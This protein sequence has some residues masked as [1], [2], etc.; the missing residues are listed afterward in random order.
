MTHHNGLTFDGTTKMSIWDDMAK[1]VGAYTGQPRTP[2][3]WYWGHLHLGTVYNAN[4]AAGTACKCRCVGH[5]AFP[6]GD[7][8]GIELQQKNVD[9]NAKTPIAPNNVK[10]QNGFAILTLRPDGSITETFYEVKND[11]SVI[12]AWPLPV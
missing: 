2:D 7:A 5:S 9:Y 12:Q 10:M 11:G 3:F 1:T 4:S 6:F 8:Y